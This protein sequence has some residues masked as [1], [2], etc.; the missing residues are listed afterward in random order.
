M[1]VRLR[2]QPS[3]YGLLGVTLTLHSDLAFS[4]KA[5]SNAASQEVHPIYPTG[6]Q[7][8]DRTRVRRGPPFSRPCSQR[9]HC[10]SE[11]NMLAG[12]A[13]YQGLRL[14]ARHLRLSIVP[15]QVIIRPFAGIFL[16][17]LGIFAG[18]QRLP[19]AVHGVPTSPQAAGE[20]GTG[21][22]PRTFP[23]AGSTESHLLI[24]LGKQYTRPD[25]KDRWRSPS[26]IA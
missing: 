8:A 25:S 2:L 22:L 14:E 3:R 6:F 10:A 11:S 20:S 16:P 17:Y 5:I 4:A 9:G 23:S 15:G 7:E 1:P 26:R 18:I 12:H 19:H 13:S 21:D 24:C